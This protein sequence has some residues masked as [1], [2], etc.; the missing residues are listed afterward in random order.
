M[1]EVQQQAQSNRSTIQPRES[2]LISSET[3]GNIL[4]LIR[5]LKQLEVEGVI[6]TNELESKTNR[7]LKLYA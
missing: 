1:F 4:K 5:E 7:L 2:F 6:S 3:A